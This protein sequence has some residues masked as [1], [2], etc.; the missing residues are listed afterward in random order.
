M[1]TA[2]GCL[3]QARAVE[4][5]DLE[6]HRSRSRQIVAFQT[7]WLRSVNTPIY[8]DG[9]EHPPEYAAHTWGGF[10]TGEWEG[11]RLK[12]Q[13]THLKE[14]YYRRNGVPQSDKATLTEYLIRR[15][16]N[17][18]DYLTWLIVAYDPVYL[19]EPLVRSTEYRIG[20]EPARNRLIRALS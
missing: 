2:F 18:E 10:S 20:P 15:R 16:F 6:G 14:D 8:L 17:D 7:E 12:I 13:T 4:L 3:H 9:R 19:T 1:P 11:D 5:K